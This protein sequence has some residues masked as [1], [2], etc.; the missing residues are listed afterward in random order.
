MT[1]SDILLDT[2]KT[3]EEMDEAKLSSNSKDHVGEMADILEDLW[4]VM[5]TFEKNDD[6]NKMGQHMR[7]I[8][9]RENE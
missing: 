8:F 3:L 4:S 6:F 2:N 7:K 1:R 9:N 5:L